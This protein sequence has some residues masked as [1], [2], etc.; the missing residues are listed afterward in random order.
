MKSASIHGEITTKHIDIMKYLYQLSRSSNLSG[1]EGV[2][3]DITSLMKEKYKTPCEVSDN[4]LSR[5]S[6]TKMS[7]L[8]YRLDNISQLNIVSLSD[9]A[10]IFNLEM[11]IS[12]NDKIVENLSYE[13]DLILDS[14]KYTYSK[15]LFE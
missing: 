15:S 5:G 11:M 4:F 7:S 1:L 6:S 14:K 10:S 13:L 8:R 9:E 2:S 3:T 12:G